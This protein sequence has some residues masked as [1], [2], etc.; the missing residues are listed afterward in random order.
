LAHEQAQRISGKALGFA[1]LVR[2]IER[3]V[4]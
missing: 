2:S 3:M 4:G 1:P